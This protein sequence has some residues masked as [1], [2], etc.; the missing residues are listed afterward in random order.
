MT[1][2]AHQREVHLRD[3][4]A[5]VSRHWRLVTAVT[6]VLV[7]FSWYNGR[8]QVTRYQS[9]LT[10]QI[11]SPR[12]V[13]AQLND[14]AV[15][16]LALQTDPVLSEALVL[17]TQA[18]ALQV[19]EALHLQVELT[20]P[21]VR[22]D[23]VFATIVAD[24]NYTP[25]RFVLVRRGTEGYEVQDASG[26]TVGSGSYQQPVTVWGVTLTLQPTSAEDAVPF[27]LTRR[28]SSAARPSP[29]SRSSVLK[30]WPISPRR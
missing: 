6:V 5:V 20:D 17:T 12:G 30:T 22:R 18:L 25:G 27:R 21:R 28:W 11:S 9:Q 4:V 14:R 24:S 1:R 10:V 23:E 2:V 8:N 3:L 16:E 19:V 26:A 29:S 7:G 13:F 15:D